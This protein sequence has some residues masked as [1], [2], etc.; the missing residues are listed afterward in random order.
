MFLDFKK[1]V[2]SIQRAGYN[3]VRTIFRRQ[4]VAQ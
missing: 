3:G 2:K 1:W 4:R